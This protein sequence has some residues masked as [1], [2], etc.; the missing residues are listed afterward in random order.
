MASEQIFRAERILN[1]EF[2]SKNLIREALTA[3]GAEQDNYDGNRRLAQGGMALTTFLLNIEG[4]AS[5]LTPSEIFHH[6]ARLSNIKHCAMVTIRCGIDRCIN[7][8]PRSGQFSQKV[9]AKALNAVIAAVFLDSNWDLKLC[10]RTLQHIG[11][12]TV[13]NG[14]VDPGQLSLP[15]I[16]NGGN[17]RGTMIHPVL[18]PPSNVGNED[19]VDLA[20]SGVN[21]DMYDCVSADI[22]IFSS[23]TAPNAAGL[24][25]RDCGLLDRLIDQP[26]HGDPGNQHVSQALSPRPAKRK[27]VESQPIAPSST[28]LVARKR[29]NMSWNNKSLTGEDGKQTTLGR[30]FTIVASPQAIAVLQ[31]A[32]KSIRSH[33]EPD[34]FRNYQAQSLPERYK[35]I[36][37][38]DRRIASYHFLRRFHILNLYQEFAG[39]R[40]QEPWS[41]RLTTPSDFRT[42]A[43]KA[44]NPENLADSDITKKMMKA[45]FPDLSPSAGQEYNKRYKYVT[46]IRRL[47]H[48]LMLMADKF[49]SGVIYLLP[50]HSLTGASEVLV[51]DDM[52][53]ESSNETFSAFLGFLDASQGPNLRLFSD[54][55]YRM[56]HSVL[57]GHRHLF[58]IL[59]VE[60]VSEQEI[61][62]EEKW[63][64]R[65]L[66]I[67]G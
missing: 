60:E 53:L 42:Q 63:S 51:S 28:T 64:H 6:R 47:G 44:G 12:F 2:H 57:S 13:E 26:Q 23:A 31:A 61:L 54:R 58:D 45:I 43:R 32:V 59:A 14:A 40:K 20:S 35:M 17:T 15:A 33:C 8:N 25:P 29:S 4:I 48:R 30:I 65:L 16:E 36:E 62:A 10:S 50:A 56:L 39:S 27:R 11:F 37:A 22:S 67:L 52:I 49:G 19:Y 18:L 5:R 1:H 7:Y 34:W 38:C 46:K 21:L 3:A 9:L 55:V 24:K 66:S 41:V